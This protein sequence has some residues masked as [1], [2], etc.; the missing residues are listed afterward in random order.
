MTDPQTEPIKIIKTVLSRLPLYYN[1][2]LEKRKENY[3]GAW[4]SLFLPQYLVPLVPLMR[5]SSGWVSRGVATVGGGRREWGVLWPIDLSHSPQRARPR[6]DFV[7]D[8]LMKRVLIY[9][10]SY[11]CRHTV[12]SGICSRS[13][14]PGAGHHHGRSVS[15]VLLY[16]LEVIFFWKRF[17]RY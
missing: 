17:L 2:L 5:C 13:A 12:F 6:E 10:Y 15:L 7:T 11:A 4:P 3:M 16:D 14:I 9:S 1:F 8:W